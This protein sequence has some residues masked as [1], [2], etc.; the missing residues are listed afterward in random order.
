[1]SAIIAPT[2]GGLEL[3]FKMSETYA[4]SLASEALRSAD[5]MG[6]F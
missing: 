2:L 4:V 5:D 6:I 3:Q 1:M